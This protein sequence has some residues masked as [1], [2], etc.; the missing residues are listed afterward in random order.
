MSLVGI[1]RYNGLCSYA[2]QKGLSLEEG[3]EA[4]KSQ[5]VG[6][7]RL[8]T[9][10]SLICG[11][12]T[13]TASRILSSSRLHQTVTRLQYHLMRLQQSNGSLTL[14]IILTLFGW[15]TLQRSHTNHMRRGV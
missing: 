13:R 7:N 6:S 12:L 2:E 1:A 10:Q 8:A 15:A 3:L 4:L 14:F 11:G 5:R 9:I